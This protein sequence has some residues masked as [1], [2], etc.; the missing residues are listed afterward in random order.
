[1]AVLP[2]GRQS[3]PSFET[4]LPLI[5]AAIHKPSDGENV[6]AERYPGSAMA[7]QL[8]PASGEIAPVEVASL[9]FE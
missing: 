6:T 9:A 1:M 7:D 5:P 3:F 2:M 8:L 4:S